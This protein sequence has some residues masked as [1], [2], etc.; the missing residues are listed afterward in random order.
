[1]SKT[2]TARH[3]A[4]AP[5]VPRIL[6]R[7]GVL[8]AVVGAA[9][10]SAVPVAGAA[11]QGGEGKSGHQAA[12]EG[13]VRGLATPVQET[14]RGAGVALGGPLET[15]N[16]LQ[17]DPLANTGT[18]PLDNTVST[19]VADFRPVSTAALTGPLARGASL[20]ELPL[21]GPALTKVTGALHTG[22]G[23][24]PH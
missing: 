12:V 22:D 14:A 5:R 21:A 24:K 6:T 4:P 11:G 10:G 19:Q 2:R 15:V 20:D 16:N 17:L 3:K 18:D 8:T 13:L 7:A 23:V 1:M 9:L